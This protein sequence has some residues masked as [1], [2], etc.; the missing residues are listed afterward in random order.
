MKNILWV[1]ICMA[2]LVI[3]RA[4]GDEQPITPQAKIELF[5]GKDLTGWVAHSK[6][7]VPAA[8]VWSVQDGLL[9]CVGKPNG[10]LRTEKSYTNYKV[11]VAWR[12]AK[13]GN[14]G[15][16]VHMNGPE[17]VWPLCVVCQGMH[18]AQGDMYYWSGAKCKELTKG[19]KV[20]RKGADAEKKV[21]E[22][23]IYQVVCANDTLTIIVNGQ[24][25]NRTSGC[26]PSTGKIGLQ[27][28]G[29]QLEVRRITLEPLSP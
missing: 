17:K 25:M 5:N 7:N 3:A 19:V 15:V 23:N 1:L 4:A 12:F 13:A 14:T 20:P 6:S 21:G 29:A 10:Y 27:S 2:V 22:W 8:Q 9:K 16:L 11:T 28:E 26:V 24:E 18:N